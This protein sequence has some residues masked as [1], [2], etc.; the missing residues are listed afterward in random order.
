MLN[1]RST[2]TSLVTSSAV[3]A[4]NSPSSKRGPLRK[5]LL[6]LLFSASAGTALAQSAP[7]PKAPKSQIQDGIAAAR[8]IGTMNAADPHRASTS[9][10][11][12][13]PHTPNANRGIFELCLTC[14][15]PVGCRIRSESLP[16]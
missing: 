10:K 8:R 11:P 7:A 9:H 15:E 2:I 1:P 6:S 5:L 3:D 14:C 13:S 16:S 4:S 12:K